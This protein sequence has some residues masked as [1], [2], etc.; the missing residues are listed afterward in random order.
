MLP[1]SSAVVRRS[2][3]ARYGSWGRA[4]TAVSTPDALRDSA[5]VSPAGPAPITI[6]CVTNSELMVLVVRQLPVPVS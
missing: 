2:A 6:A 3:A 1:G 4:A 5:A